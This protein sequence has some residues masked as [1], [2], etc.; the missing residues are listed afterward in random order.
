MIDNRAKNT[1]WHFAKTGK[2]RRV[3]RP[4]KDML[5]TYEEAVGT[6]TESTTSPGVWLGTF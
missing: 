1:F 3:T 5:H 6:V 2:Y 4:E